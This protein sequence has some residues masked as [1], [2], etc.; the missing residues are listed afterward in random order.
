M[1][2][3][4]AAVVV[5]VLGCIFG[6]G[7][8]GGGAALWYFKKVRK[9][10][11]R[12]AAQR[13]TKPDTTAVAVK[14]STKAATPVASPRKDKKVSFEASEQTCKK[15]EVLVKACETKFED[16]V[17]ADSSDISQ[18]IAS[19]S[20]ATIAEAAPSVDNDIGS[21]ASPALSPRT[22][23]S[24]VSPASGSPQYK[25]SPAGSSNLSGDSNVSRK[26]IISATSSRSGRSPAADSYAS[27]ESGHR[28][29]MSHI[30][31]SPRSPSRAG[32]ATSTILKLP[33]CLL[34]PSEPNKKSPVV[35]QKKPEV[36]QEDL[37]AFF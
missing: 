22:P 11:K 25:N 36:S 10:R 7:S 30:Y 24:E 18:D 37:M 31:T 35:D 16:M 1:A 14:P 9:E 8:I 23:P 34:S 21:K 13:P 20:G 28:S 15:P 4:T 29:Y 27:D 3:G 26:S 12:V 2:L 32:S 17:K 6:A 33:A 19:P 5:I